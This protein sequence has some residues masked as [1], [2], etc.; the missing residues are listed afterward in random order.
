MIKHT[1]V[2]LGDP[3]QMT[4]LYFIGIQITHTHTHTCNSQLGGSGA[5]RAQ[6][7]SRVYMCRTSCTTFF[8]LEMIKIYDRI[9]SNLFRLFCVVLKE[10]FSF[11]YIHGC[12]SLIFC[13]NAGRRDGSGSKKTTTTNKGNIK[14]A[15]YYFSVVVYFSQASLFFSF[16]VDFQTGLPRPIS[17][18]SSPLPLLLALLLSGFANSLNAF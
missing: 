17:K 9:K 7:Y 12:S 2:P 6:I 13:L 4:R 1:A 14:Q 15:L 8:N 11:I 10:I 3:S 18:S 16:Q 5:L